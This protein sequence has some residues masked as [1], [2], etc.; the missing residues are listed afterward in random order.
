MD[1]RGRSTIGVCRTGDAPYHQ[2]LGLETAKL[3]KQLFDIVDGEVK[4]RLAPDTLLPNRCTTHQIDRRE[5]QWE[6]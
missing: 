5:M 2:F 1:G 6:N 4:T 3:E